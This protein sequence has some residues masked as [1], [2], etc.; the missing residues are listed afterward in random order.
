[1]SSFFDRFPSTGYICAHRGACSIA[2]ENTML[3]LEKSRDCG[4]DLWETDIQVTADGELVLFH[5][6]SLER[7]TDIAIHPEFS[8]RHPWNLVEFTYEELQKLDAG[9]WFLQSDPFE[10]ISKGEVSKDDFSAIR[11]QRI[12]LLREILN[13][14]RKYDFPVNLEIKD[15]A[16]TAVDKIIIGQVLD[17]LK[18][19]D[20]AHLVLLS[21]FNHD[22]LRQMKR[23]NPT[24]ATA[25]LVK[26]HPENLLVYLRDLGVD[27]Y[28]PDQLITDNVLIRELTA[29]GIRVNLW[30]VNSLNRAQYFIKAGATF[31]YTDWPQRM[32][33]SGHST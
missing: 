7:T 26:K 31:I 13:N 29:A 9:S 10:T 15:Q 23:F 3:A 11:K 14:C 6:D 17:L 24:I 25:A 18:E 16:G 32:V 8:D 33:E 19:T 22:Y 28:H 27:A 20:T 2:P 12:P 30:T 4:A 21:S 5:D 1:M